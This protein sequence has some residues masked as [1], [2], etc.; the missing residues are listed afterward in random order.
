MYQ[1]RIENKFMKQSLQFQRFCSTFTSLK[2][3]FSFLEKNPLVGLF[4]DI[5]A[6]V[7]DTLYRLSFEILIHPVESITELFKLWSTEE[8]SLVHTLW[9]KVYEGNLLWTRRVIR[10]SRC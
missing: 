6:H 7:A 1:F 3:A 2:I 5:L 4:N 10:V 9:Y 8:A